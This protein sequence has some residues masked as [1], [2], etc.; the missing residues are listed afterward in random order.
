MPVGVVADP[1]TARCAAAASAAEQTRLKGVRVKHATCV[2]EIGIHL[3]SITSGVG[4]TAL[5]IG[6]F[7]SIEGCFIRLVLFES[8]QGVNDVI[9]VDGWVM[10]VQILLDKLDPFGLVE[11]CHLFVLDVLSRGETLPFF[12]LF[13]RNGL[14]LNI[15]D[16]LLR[17]GDIFLGLRLSIFDFLL[18]NFIS[19][20]FLFWGG[21]D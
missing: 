9:P 7:F 1:G 14:R 17:N 4:S 5:N 10:S 15:F 3:A 18:R 6:T 13:Y 21:L 20:A 11:I 8:L 12:F 19:L 16:I 2:R